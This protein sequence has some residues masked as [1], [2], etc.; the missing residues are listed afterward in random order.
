MVVEL[1]APGASALASIVSAEL[2]RLIVSPEDTPPPA[3]R[4]LLRFPMEGLMV[5]AS[6]RLTE[7]PGRE[8]AAVL[9][10]SFANVQRLERRATHRLDEPVRVR[11]QAGEEHSEARVLPAVNISERG[12]LLGW[13]EQPGVVLGEQVKMGIA[14]GRES[15]EAT[16]EVVRTDD[17]HSAIKFVEITLD[18]RDHITSYVFRR[19]RERRLRETPYDEL[20]GLPPDGEV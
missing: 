3:G 19:E 13:P 11:V 20:P 9:L 12:L 16:G 7:L 8:D 5:Q 17:C 15:I 10:D 14:L 2:G 18:A 6:A 1:L 4:V